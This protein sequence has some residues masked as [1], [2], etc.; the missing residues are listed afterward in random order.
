MTVEWGI[1]GWVDVLAQLL[2]RRLG[3]AWERGES[4][5]SFHYLPAFQ[6]QPGHTSTSLCHCS[7]FTGAGPACIGPG[8]AGRGRNNVGGGRQETGQPLHG[9]RALVSESTAGRV[10]SA[11]VHRR[12]I[13]GPMQGHGR[14]TLNRNLNLRGN[15]ESW[16]G[17]CRRVR[18]QE[19]FVWI[20]YYINP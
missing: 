5:G 15:A 3:P 19:W 6:G 4:Q 16:R 7:C 11:D 8:R 1:V 10:D 13:A 20:H 14:G 9:A 12:G 17:G 18:R 2:T